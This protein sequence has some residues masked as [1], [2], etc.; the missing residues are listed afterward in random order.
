MSGAWHARRGIDKAS[1]ID[2]SK[3]LGS[4]DSKESESEVGYG[5]PPKHTRF[6]PG[7]SGNPRGRPKGAKNKTNSIP[8]LGAERLKSVIMEEAYR[9]LGVNDGD[10][11]VEIPVIQAV[12]RSMALNAAKGN[13]RAQRMFTEMIQ[14]VE[15]ENKALHNEYL[16]TMIEYKVEGEKELERCKRAGLTAPEMFP[17]PDDIIIDFTTGD[18]K[19]MGPMSKEEKKIWDQMRQA[20]EQSKKDLRKFKKMAAKDPD[21]PEIQKLIK[22]VQGIVERYSPYLRD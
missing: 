19:I 14:W 3:W 13:Q 2:P 8:E 4:S 12:I 5:K 18:V 15:G 9:S 7:Q 1:K 11:L 22:R 10:R 17:H 20:T 21:N 6:E 16:K